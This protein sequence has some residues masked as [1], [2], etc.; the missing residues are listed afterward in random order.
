MK[1]GDNIEFNGTE[2]QMECANKRTIYSS[3]HIIIATGGRPEPLSIPGGDLALTSD[4]FFAQTKLPHKV[5]IIGAGYIAVEMACVM[6]SFGAQV[7]LFIR[8][9]RPLRTFDSTVSECLMQQLLSS[10]INIH[11]NS[12]V[13]SISKCEDGKLKLNVNGDSVFEGFDQVYAAIGRVPNVERLGLDR[14]GVELTSDGLIKTDEY[15]NTTRKG[16]YA[17]GDVCGPLYLTPVA[18][19]AGRNL[20]D[21]LFGTETTKPFDY[22]NVPTVVFSHPPIGTVGLTEQQ[23]RTKY[24][25]V[26]VYKCDFTSMYYALSSNEKHKPKTVFKLVCQGADERIVGIHLFGQGSDEI[27]QGFAVAVK[28]GAKKSDLDKTVAIHPT[29]AEELVTMR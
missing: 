14:V 16:V 21:R 27:L 8:F 19:A 13:D 17:V 22:T 6:N 5:A 26:K 20:V 1:Q 12:N 18:I 24:N 29:S 4:D 28:M 9:D 3:Q 7:D 11:S 25:D 10:G 15:Q 23:A 2:L